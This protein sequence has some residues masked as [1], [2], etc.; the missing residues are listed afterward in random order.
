MTLRE[1]LEQ[2]VNSTRK[3]VIH[4]LRQ[5]LDLEREDGALPRTWR[6]SRRS[7]PVGKGQSEVEAVKADGHARGL[8]EEALAGQ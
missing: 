1:K 4:R 3:P 7:W 2:S 6:D 8:Q 5:G